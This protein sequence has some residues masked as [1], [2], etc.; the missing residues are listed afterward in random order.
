MRAGFD[1]LALADV[2]IVDFG[3]SDE[4][5]GGKAVFLVVRAADAGIN[6]A[7]ALA[8]F[9]IAGRI[10]A[11]GEHVD[12]GL[13]VVAVFVAKRANNGE[14]VGVLGKKRKIAAERETGNFGFD[15]AGDAAIRRGRGEVGIERFDVARPA[16]EEKQ[17]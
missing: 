13:G 1:A 14:L 3:R 11:A 9:G 7:H 16:A 12:D 2:L 15:F 6:R 5:I 10:G 4:A 17:N 8:K